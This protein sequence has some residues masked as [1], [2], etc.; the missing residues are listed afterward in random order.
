MQLQAGE[1]TCTP[2]HMRASMRATRSNARHTHTQTHLLKV[3]SEGLEVHDAP[4]GDLIS[5]QARAVNPRVSKPQ[6]KHAQCR[7]VGTECDV[8]QCDK[9]VVQPVRTCVCVCAGGGG[10]GEGEERRGGM[11]MVCVL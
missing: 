6:V 9:C 5:H 7:L 11:G 2:A 1:D 4:V 3:A 8:T 10:E